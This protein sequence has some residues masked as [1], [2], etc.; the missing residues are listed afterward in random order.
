MATGTAAEQIIDVVTPAAGESV[1]EGTILEWHVKVGDFIKSN[2]TIVE[3]STDKVDLEL[4]SPASGIA[5]EIPDRRGRDGDRRQVIARTQPVM[6]RRQRRRA[7]RRRARARA[8]PSAPY[9]HPDTQPAAARRFPTRCAA[10]QRA[11][12][13]AARRRQRH[14][15]RARRPR[16]RSPN[17]ALAEALTSQLWPGAV[18]VE[19]R[20]PTCRLQSGSSALAVRRRA[21]ARRPT[22]GT[23]DGNRGQRRAEE[24]RRRGAARHMEQRVRSPLP[25]ASASPTVRCPTRAARAQGGGAQRC[26]THLIACDRSRRDRDAV[27]TNHWRSRRAPHRV[28]D[29]Q[30]PRAGG[31][32]EKRGSRTR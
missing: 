26:P 21:P 19:L 31:D 9:S 20:S 16:R 11:A 5:T 10:E 24:W 3:I 22:A 6:R 23:R 27:M 17:A 7:R 4:P 1:S 25:P 2:D 12:P 30:E 18:P 15:R 8:G 28:R 29:G 13:T 14:R 32:V